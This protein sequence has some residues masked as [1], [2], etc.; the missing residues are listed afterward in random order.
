M[1]A[2]WKHGYGKLKGV[3]TDENDLA[4]MKTHTTRA[5]CGGT[6]RIHPA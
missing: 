1:A 5:T 2:P 3:E 4:V 6:G